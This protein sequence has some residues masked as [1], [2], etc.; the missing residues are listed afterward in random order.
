M[1]HLALH[2][3][4]NL[5]HSMIYLRVS[6]NMYKLRSHDAKAHFSK[7]FL[8]RALWVLPQ[9]SPTLRGCNLD[10]EPTHHHLTWT[11]AH[12]LSCWAFPFFVP[13]LLKHCWVPQLLLLGVK[14]ESLSR[15][16]GYLIRGCIWGFVPAKLWLFY[17]SQLQFVWI[18]FPHENTYK[19]SHC[20]EEHGA[21]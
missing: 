10:I 13:I 19:S 8:L 6:I 17:I 2:P 11:V 21:Q 5:A 16:S 1:V 20:R 15:A 4:Q 7:R 12:D 14:L 9:V 18:L 3:S